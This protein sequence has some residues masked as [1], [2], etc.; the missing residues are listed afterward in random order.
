MS[1]SQTDPPDA[2]AESTAP[3]IMVRGEPVML[4]TR[5]AQVFE[6][7]TREVVQAVKRNPLKFPETHAFELTRDEVESLTS[8][9]VISKPGR[10]GSRAL[11]WAFTHKGV[12]RLAMTMN[13]PAALEATDR[14][15]DVF[16]EVQTQLARGQGHIALSNPAQILPDPHAR[17]RLGAFREK[18]FDALEALL[19][20]VID[21]RN[22]TTVRDELEELGGSALDYLKAHLRTKGIENE[23]IEA[24][25]LHIL[26][27]VREIRARTEA[28]TRKSA[29]QTET[30]Q[31]ENIDRKI[32]LVEKLLQMADRMAPNA[33]VDL[34]G[35]FAP[36]IEAAPRKPRRLT[37][38]AADPEER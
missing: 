8:H 19:G 37:H 34:L 5:V 26:E 16:I 35:N 15:I 13:A 38:R 2:E 3:V 23:R 28:D 27:K 7:A 20:T 33:V 36:H 12:V 25:T 32:A 4:A 1:T 10:G 11:P 17:H 31:L 22:N 30:I 6:V 21:Q 18:L 9:A 29:A 14:I 24:E